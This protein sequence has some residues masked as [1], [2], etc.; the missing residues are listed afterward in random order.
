MGFRSKKIGTSFLL[1]D[2]PEANQSSA[3]A[4]QQRDNTRMSENWDN[5]GGSKGKSN[6][7]SDWTEG[8]VSS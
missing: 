3:T 7:A 1:I 8:K 5:Y 6:M 2:D 4:N